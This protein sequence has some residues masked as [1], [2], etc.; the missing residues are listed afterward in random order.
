MSYVEII[1]LITGIL[2]VAM[3]TAVYIFSRIRKLKIK[4]FIINGSKE[5]K[6]LHYILK[7][8]K[9]K[10]INVDK[11]I[12]FKILIG[13]KTNKFDFNVIALAKKK[14]KR[15]VCFMQQDFDR[16]LDYEMFFKTIMAKCIRGLVVDPELFE[17]Q[18]YQ[19]KLKRGWRRY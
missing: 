13:D 15:Y 12:K 11:K 7:I 19:L 5:I 1:T 16:V 4:K 17:L 9:F 8:N 6:R 2:V 3:L 10:I 14:K 18:E